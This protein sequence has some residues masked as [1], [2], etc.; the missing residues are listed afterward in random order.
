MNILILLRLETI[1]CG[2]CIKKKRNNEKQ[3]KTSNKNEKKE[4]MVNIAVLPTSLLYFYLQVKS[5]CKLNLLILTV[6]IYQLDFRNILIRNRGKDADRP[7]AFVVCLNLKIL[8]KKY[9]YEGLMRRQM[10]H[11]D[12]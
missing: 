5:S 4:H 2:K 6:K 3:D 9:S 7:K 1:C 10:N 11:D 8:D 12:I